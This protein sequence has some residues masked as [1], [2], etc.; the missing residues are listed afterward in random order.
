MIHLGPFDI[1]PRTWMLRR[2]GRPVDLSPRLVEILAFLAQRNGEIVTKEELLEKFWPDVNVTENTL[3]RAIADIRIALG[4]TA[5]E[6][7]YIQTLARRGYKWVASR[8]SGPQDP[9]TSG[10][11]DPRTSGPQDHPAVQISRRFARFCQTH[12]IALGSQQA[13]DRGQGREGGHQVAG[14]HF[15]AVLEPFQLHRRSQAH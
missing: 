9:K 1:D 11:Q 4:D 2:D 14:P 15:H 5:S 7:K 3:T 8:T 6:P 13:D 10:P 12:E